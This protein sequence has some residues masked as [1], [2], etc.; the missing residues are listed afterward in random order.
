[1]NSKWLFGNFD[2]EIKK[3][4]EGVLIQAE[5]ELRGC[6]YSKLLNNESAKTISTDQFFDLETLHQ[7]L[8]DYLEKKP[9][10]TSLSISENG[11]LHYSCQILIGSVVKKLEFN[12]QLE[13]QELDAVTRLE[14][15]VNKLSAKMLKFENE[16]SVPLDVFQNFERMIFERLEKLEEILTRNEIRMDQLEKISKIQERDWEFNLTPELQTRF[17]VTN[18]L[19]TASSLTNSAGSILAKQS[20]TKGKTSKFTFLI[21]KT[22]WIMVGITTEK[23]LNR[24]LAHHDPAAFAYTHTGNFFIDK[25]SQLGYLSYKEGDQVSFI[26]DMETGKIQVFLNNN[27]IGNHEISKQDLESNIFYPFLYTNLDAGGGATFI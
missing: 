13:K 18:G 24:D 21:G 11:K 1:M 4:D 6:L 7:L 17:K 19:K 3:T 16:R 8:R 2:I 9:E 20:L 14:N 5:Y 26:C 25:T 15:Q 12:L 23:Q 27:L 22:N 10:N